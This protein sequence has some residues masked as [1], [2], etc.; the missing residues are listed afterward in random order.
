MNWEAIG[1]IGEVIGAIAVVST[2]IY[3]SIQ[4]RGLSADSFS[5]S[6]SRVNEGERELSKMKQNHAALIIKANSGAVLTEEEEFV[7]REIFF[8]HWV[9]HLI[10]YLRSRTY[11][12]DGAINVHN[13]TRT[14]IE[15][16]CFLQLFRNESWRS[17]ANEG[18]FDYVQQIDKRLSER[19]I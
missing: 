4:I 10:A 14:L 12:R 5:D 1:S 17:G 19:G 6:L 13:M 8:S 11:G 7:L 18:S 2:L 16:P 15:Y 3:F 9:F